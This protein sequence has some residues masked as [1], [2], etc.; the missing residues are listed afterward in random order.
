VAYLAGHLRACHRAIREGVPLKGYFVSS[1][2]D[3]FEWSRGYGKRFGMMYVD[4]RTQR[5]IP[6]ASAAWYAEA[7]RRNG[8]EGGSPS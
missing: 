8:L 4:Y 3:N 6:K 2:L 5:R 7:I 1:L